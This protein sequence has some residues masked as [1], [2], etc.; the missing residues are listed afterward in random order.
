MGGTLTNLDENP[1]VTIKNGSEEVITGADG[2]KYEN[3][4]SKR[5]SN[6]V[7]YIEVN[8]PPRKF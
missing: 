2:T 3:V 5:Y 4:K 8:L 6:G 1:Q 7:Y